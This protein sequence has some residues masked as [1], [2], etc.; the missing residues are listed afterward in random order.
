MDVLSL[1]IGVGLGAG[2]AALALWG[3][4]GAATV[5]LE[6]ANARAEELLG[7]RD[8]ARARMETLHEELA[9]ADARVAGQETLLKAFDDASAK[10]LNE[11][12]GRFQ[13][14]AQGRFRE[15]QELARRRAEAEKG[16][17]GRLLEP[18]HKEL[19]DLERLTRD[20]ERARVEAEGALN[21][22]LQTLQGASESLAGA[23]KKPQ[24]RGSWGEEQLKR[25]LESGGLVEGTHY[26]MQDHT[27]E[28]GQALRTDVVILLPKGREIVVDSKA[29][30]DNYWAAMNA[31][32]D[33]ERKIRAEAHAC[34]VRGHFRTLKGKE[35]WKRYAGSP[36]YVILFLPQEGAYQLACEHD[37]ALLTDCHAAKVILANP[38]TLMNL[39]HLA[40]YALQED[41]MK[42]DMEKVRDA[43]TTL[44]GRLGHVLGLVAKHR[45]HLVATVDSYNEIVGSV[46]RRLL[47]ST[48]EMQRLGVG[49]AKLSDVPTRIETT[50]KIL[51]V[52]EAV[53]EDEPLV[54]DL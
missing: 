31:T 8:A 28:D 40:S 33:E 9:R 51:P 23:L 47:P 20:V 2:M 44:C 27:E 53:G 12:L 42:G 4:G 13:D 22:K 46:D 16:E 54:L 41:R 29:P 45:R 3:R 7:E 39:V 32:T 15:E 21:A 38:M 49:D 24:V 50:F 36:D 26:K 52:P 18:M 25:I 5:R 11:A 14:Q 30:L 34:N 6:A 35:Y 37:R 43:A 19:E 17:I 1:S 48:R 10:A